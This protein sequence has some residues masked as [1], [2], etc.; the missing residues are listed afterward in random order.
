MKYGATL[1]QDRSGAN[2]TQ[3]D[4]LLGTYAFTAGLTGGTGNALANF[5]LGIPSTETRQLE[6]IRQHF[7]YK[8]IEFFAQDAIEFN[9]KFTLSVGLRYEYHQPPFEPGS[10]T[11]NLNLANGNII[12]YNDA[13]KNLIPTPVLTNPSF[14]FQT[15]AAAGYP[16]HLYSLSTLN[17]A[18]RLGL[19]YRLDDKTVVRSGYGIFYDFAPPSATPSDIFNVAQG[20]APNV[21]GA[22]GVPTYQFPAPFAGASPAAVGTLTP[23]SYDQHLRMPYTEQWSLTAERQIVSTVAI[24]AS[25]IGSRTAEQM[26]GRPANIPALS[27][28]TFAQANRPFPQFGQITAYKSGANANYNGLS[29]QAQYRGS[30]GIYAS[31]SF[32]WAHN[33]GI[34]GQNA[35]APIIMN[36]YNIHQ[37][38]GDVINPTL[39]STG[40][41]TVPLPV[42]RGR[43]YF[44]TMNWF[45]DAILGGWNLTSN[46]LLR[47]GDHVTPVYSGYDSTGTGITSARPD[48]TGNPNLP[49]NQ[50]GIAQWYNTAAFAYPGGSGSGTGATHPAMPI[51][52]F[53]NAGVGILEGPGYQQVDLGIA[54]QFTIYEQYKL[55]FFALGN[56]AL[57]HPSFADPNLTVLTTTSGTITALKADQD[58]AVT[59][60]G[61]NRQLELGMRFEF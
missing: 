1:T 39:V 32:T 58:A 43:K 42:G 61:G 12:L 13:A 28:T 4:N 56:N 54:K 14:T 10:A 52:R 50:R 21:I 26:Y 60:T 59:T 37:D 41:F 20:F 27:T 53:G 23:S 44:A 19:A 31:F 29:T 25:Y 9:R 5:L 3:P 34:A 18:P 47:S 2:S 11:Y 7:P 15:A 46:L 17:F 35:A 8:T 57:N 6:F 24:R 16:A 38:Y 30:T 55:N 49:K 51:G 48:V 40:V 33:L 22:G 36:P 45:S